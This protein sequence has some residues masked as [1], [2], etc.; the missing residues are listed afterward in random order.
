[1]KIEV[2]TTTDNTP[3]KTGFGSHSTCSEVVEALQRAGNI[4]RLTVCGCLDDLEAV[5]VRNPDLV[6]LAEKFFHNQNA[7]I[8]WF[9][10]YFAHNKI[11]FSGSD[12]ETLKFDSDKAS[13]KIHLANIKIKTARHFTALPKQFLSE[14]SLPLA[15]PLFVKSIDAIASNGIDALSY[16]TNFTEFEAKVLS[17]CALDGQPALVEEYL[18]GRDFTV[19]IICNSNGEMTMSS[20]EIVRQG[21]NQQDTDCSLQVMEPDDSDKVNEL[22]KAAFLGLGLRDFAL[23]DVRMN[24]YGQCF[25]MDA[26]LVPNMAPTS[27]CFLRACKIANNLSYDQIICLMLKVFSTRVRGEKLH[28]NVL[29]QRSQHWPRAS[30]TRGL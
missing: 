22:A 26:D 23:I 7:E 24:N 18:P 12:R 25:F 21:D 11:T 13:A 19:A 9:S 4:V 10:E 20:I 8:I 15:F 3:K 2:I 29:K 27:S 5:V 30:V 17:I 6:V 16:V 1:M 14:S 28:N